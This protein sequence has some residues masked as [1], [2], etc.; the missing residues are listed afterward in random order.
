MELSTYPTVSNYS[1]MLYTRRYSHLFENSLEKEFISLQ[2]TQT[3]V[4]LQKPYQEPDADTGEIREPS[5]I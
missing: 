2:G 4:L 1:D 3:L 5:F